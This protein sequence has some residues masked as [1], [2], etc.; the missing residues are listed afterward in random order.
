MPDYKNP[1]DGREYTDKQHVETALYEYRSMYVGKQYDVKGGDYLGTV[2]QIYDN[3]HGNEEQ[4]YVLTNNGKGTKQSPVPYSASDTERAQVQDVTVMMQGSQT[5]THTPK[6]LHDTVTDWLPTDFVT[7]AHRLGPVGAVEHATPFVYRHSQNII[8]QK[9]REVLDKA[10]R[11]A[12]NNIGDAVG[13]FNKDVGQAVTR[14][15][16]SLNK[17]PFNELR[18]DVLSNSAGIFGGAVVTGVTSTPIMLAAGGLKLTQ[19]FPPAQFE[20]AA[21]HLKETIRK[22]PNAKIDLYGH[23]LGSMD[24]QYALASLTEEEMRHIGTVH[25]Y[26]GPNIYPLLTKEQKARL[27]SAK[28]KI[29]NHIDHKD[30]VSLGYSLS[31]SENAAGIVRHIKTIGKS[32]DD[33]HMMKGYIYDKNKNFVLMDGTGKITIKD[34]I[35]V[36]MIPYQN[37]KK[38]L[39]KGGFSGN[40]KIYLDSVQAQAIAQNL[41]NVAKLGYETLQQARD[42]VVGEAE[43]LAD[44][45][46]KVPWGFSLSPDE[47]VAAY[48]AGGVDYQSLVLSLQEHF[49]SR[50]SKV[51]A[52]QTTF[53]DLIEQLN[54]GIQQLLDK[55]QV[56]A[57]DFEQWNQVKQ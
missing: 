48:Q 30:I 9:S 39:S 21:K 47:V 25:I 3:V 44:E 26:N 19:K 42:Q 12:S 43:I 40:E 16:N 17:N 45:L 11:D 22:Y 10:D 23:S 14:E 2:S 13:F 15:L 27:D 46:H 7:A 20:D 32:I 34:T 24:I 56:L 37:M 35:K 28:Y 38:Y 55:D 29:F 1:I 54:A 57:G 33:Q 6:L 51:Q 50:L 5:K 4:V 49:D 36:N 41:V 8:T 31:G 53:T 52:L 18:K